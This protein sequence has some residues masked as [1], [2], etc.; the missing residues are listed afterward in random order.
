MEFIEINK[1]A[2]QAGAER[3]GVSVSRTRAPSA[4]G[5]QLEYEKKIDQ[6]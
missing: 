2:R 3:R 1:G 5:P 6:I 4:L